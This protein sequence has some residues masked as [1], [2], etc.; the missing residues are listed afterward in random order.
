MCRYH[1][2]QLNNDGFPDIVVVKEDGPNQLFLNLGADLTKQSSQRFN[3][4]EE[5]ADSLIAQSSGTDSMGVTI[6]E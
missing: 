2:L 4:F 6:G 5:Q 3:G 1:A